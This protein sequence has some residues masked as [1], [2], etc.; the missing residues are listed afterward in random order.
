MLVAVLD[1]ASLPIGSSR[2]SGPRD[3]RA[4][5][6]A[7]LEIERAADPR[8]I[9]NHRADRLE[10]LVQFDVA[11]EGRAAGEQRSARL[12]LDRR[13]AQSELVA[14]LG[15][16]QPHEPDQRCP[17]HEAAA[18]D[19]RSVGA[20]R[21]LAAVDPRLRQPQLPFDAGTGTAQ[22][23]DEAGARHLPV[24]ADRDHVGADRRLAAVDLDAFGVERLADLGAV[25][26]DAAANACRDRG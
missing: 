11:P 5:E 16:G 10:A 14:D 13:R 23:P 22:L 12:D 15:R 2:Q 25:Q 21:E 1:G 4:L 3:R 6:V 17:R 7:A 24:A 20:D 26:D 19:A 9:E 18:A 8:V